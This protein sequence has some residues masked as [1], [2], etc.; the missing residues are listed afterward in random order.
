MVGRKRKKNGLEIFASGP[1][2]SN[3]N[4]INQLVQ[5]L[6]Q[7]TD[8]KLIFFY[9]EGFSGNSRQCYRPIV[10][11]GMQA[12]YKFTKF[13]ENRSS[14]FSGNNFYKFLL[15]SDIM[16]E[17]NIAIV[18]IFD[19]DFLMIFHSTSLPES[20]NVF[21]KKCVCVCL[22]VCLSADCVCDRRRTQSLNQL[23]HLVQIRYIGSSCKY[24]EEFFLVFPLPLK[25][26]VVHIK[27]SKISNF[28]KW[29]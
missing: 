25:L 14:S 20:K 24:L 22:P 18:K 21:Q 5:Q 8:R 17:G 28:S 3:L 7:A 4:K 1:L 27:K 26:R 12:Y 2:I 23:T 10:E 19:L 11:V 6:S 9:F 16:S 15:S 13:D 29:L